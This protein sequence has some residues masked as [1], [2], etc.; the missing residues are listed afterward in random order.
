MSVYS[1]QAR[2]ISFNQ[3]HRG[4]KSERTS[5]PRVLSQHERTNVSVLFCL[6]FAAE[7]GLSDQ[8]FELRNQARNKY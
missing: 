1:L 5:S 6:F 4:Q 2:S 3:R 8:G 7:L